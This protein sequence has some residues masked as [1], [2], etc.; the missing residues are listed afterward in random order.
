MT[1]RRSDVP[2]F[3]LNTVLFPAGLLPLRIFEQRY[4]EMSKG[5]LRD[6]TPFGVCL[7]RE[8][9]EVGEPATHEDLGCLARITQW[10]MQQLGLLQLVAQGAER[11]RV[12]SERIRPDGL[13]LADIE[14]LPEQ[15]DIP[16]P[17]KFAACGQ[18]LERIVAEHGDRLFAPPFLLDSSAW[19]GARLA[20]VLPLPAAARQKL[21][22][23]DDSLRRLEILQRLLSESALGA[24]GSDQS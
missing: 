13:I 10:D 11:F 20:E 14:L 23:L 21:L 3:P 1:G 4:L 18:L 7:I 5:C 19:V 24:K 9:A 12:L 2:L 15:A 8:G 16:L 22:A 17:G 6:G